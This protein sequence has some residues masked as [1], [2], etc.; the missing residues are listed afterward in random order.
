MTSD[1]S[2]TEIAMLQM[3]GDRLSSL[4]NRLTQSDAASSASRAKMHQELEALGRTCLTI[5]M[6]VQATEKAIAGAQPTL[7]EVA[8]AKLKVAGGGLLVVGLWK[9]AMISIS[10]AVFLYAF[11]DRV[12]AV[13]RAIFTAPK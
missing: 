3:I 13:I 11:W 5:D 7:Q 6:R 10:A 4:E 2:Q 9:L 8:D 12:E 1:M